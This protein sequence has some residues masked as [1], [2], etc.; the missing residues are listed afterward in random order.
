MKYIAHC[1]TAIYGWGETEEEAMAM[2]NSFTAGEDSLEYDDWE[3]EPCTDALYAG[4]CNCTADAL[5]WGV[6]REDGRPMNCLPEEMD[7]T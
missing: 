5:S 6:R 7:G 4:L 3:V 1:E 2:A